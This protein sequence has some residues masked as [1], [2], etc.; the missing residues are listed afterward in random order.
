MTAKEIYD[1]R[2]RL[3]QERL[4]REEEYRA[5][6]DER[7]DEM[8]FILISLAASLE[9]IADALEAKIGREP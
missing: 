8:A 5:T 6:A 1:K 9:R 3:R 4:L 7:E 2:K